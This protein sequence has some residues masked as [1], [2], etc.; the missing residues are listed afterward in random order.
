MRKN[1]FFTGQPIFTQV[2]SL[3]PRSIVNRLVREYDA[4]RYCKRFRSYDHLITM[5]YC[6]FHR[7][8]S[9]REVITGM[10]ASA[11]RL[12]HLGISF[13]PRRSTLSDANERRAACF[14]EAL[15]HQ[16]Y[17]RFYGGLPDSL[18]GKRVN[19]R[20]FIID[21]TI[22]SLFSAALKSTGSYGCNGRKKGGI[23]AHLLVRAKDNLPCF[24]RLTQ[25]KDSDTSFL[26]HIALPAGSIV[27]MDKGYR[28]YQQFIKWTELQIT[29]VS[30]LHGGT[31]FKI[32][33]SRDIDSQQ[34][35]KGVQKDCLIE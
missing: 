7:C 33:K 20:L 27:V 18:K 25:G 3:I 28:S 1:N 10:Q 26:S 17:H 15:Y 21:S 32:I 6:I 12:K 14:F 35:Q 16:I 22:I 30:R 8:S 5:L 31:V 34:L 24:V 23:K 29:W 9:L 11:S 13:S 2:L 19:N 4:D